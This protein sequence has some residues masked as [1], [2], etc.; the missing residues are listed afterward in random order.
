MRRYCS[1]LS[2]R[3]V[4]IALVFMSYI[5]AFRCIFTEKALTHADALL[6]KTHA[7]GNKQIEQWTIN[8]RAAAL[9]YDDNETDPALRASIAT[10][11]N[12]LLNAHDK[13]YRS[14]SP[15]CSALH[16][17]RKT[18]DRAK[19]FYDILG[20]ALFMSAAYNTIG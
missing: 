19:I 11:E 7:D 14:F 8:H 12:E 16:A 15:L 9:F 3:N 20:F 13:S 1:Y 18:H 4:N 6:V 10:A 17:A 2:G 5:A